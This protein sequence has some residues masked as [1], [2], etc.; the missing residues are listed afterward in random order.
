MDR[1]LTFLLGHIELVAVLVGIDLEIIS[2]TLNGK[3]PNL[4]VGIIQH[5]EQVAESLF[6][7]VAVPYR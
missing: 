2:Q 3:M 4:H 1:L 6:G 7:L 5:F